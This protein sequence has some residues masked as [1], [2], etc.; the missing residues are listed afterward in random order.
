MNVNVKLI[1]DDKC[2]AYS[3]YEIKVIDNEKFIKRIKRTKKRK[4]DL[5]KNIDEELLDLLN[6]GKKA[7]FNE[8]IEDKEILV[9]I[10]KYGM[11]GLI[12]EEIL[13]NA[14]IPKEIDIREITIFSKD[15]IESINLIIFYAKSL[16][17]MLY[18]ID[19]GKE[20]I[21]VP[22]VLKDRKTEIKFIN[23][24]ENGITIE[25][26][27]LKQAIDIYFILQITNSNRKLKICKRCHKPFIAKNLNSCY[28]SSTC[29]N[30][31]NVYKSR[32][33]KKLEAGGINR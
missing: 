33:K 17:K 15:Y 28:C 25:V 31:A 12:L 3:N 9:Y 19:K 2:C 29:R 4:V 7:Y 20:E 5:I 8:N 11:F 32:A 10:N 27:S 13:R 21:E 18:E 1:T 26:I 22:N 14:N 16:Y 23:N 24:I 30:I 6:I